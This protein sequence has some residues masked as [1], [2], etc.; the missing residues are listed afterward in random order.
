M[1]LSTPLIRKLEEFR[2]KLQAYRRALTVPDCEAAAQAKSDARL[3][4][5]E[6]KDDLRTL[7]VPRVGRD[8]AGSEFGMFETALESF[9]PQ[10]ADLHFK[11]IDLALGSLEE[12]IGRVRARELPAEAARLK[13]Q[14]VS[15]SEDLEGYRR[16]LNAGNLS[17]ARDMRPKL[18]QQIAVLEPRLNDIGVDTFF[19][20]GE[21]TFSTLKAAVTEMWSAMPVVVARR[22]AYALDNSFEM[23]AN[24]QVMLREMAPK[25]PEI[26]QLESGESPTIQVAQ[27]A[28]SATTAPQ[29]V[30]TA[31]EV[32]IVVQH[33][34][35]GFLLFAAGVLVGTVLGWSVALHQAAV[36]AA[37]WSAVD[38]WQK[39]SVSSQIIFPAAT[40]I[41]AVSGSMLASDLKKDG[42]PAALRW[43]GNAEA[44]LVIASAVAAA[45]TAR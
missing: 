20:E 36:I 32:R 1:P 3:L 6:V 35:R 37:F 5:G 26:V 21:D 28:A 8:S 4:Y 10:T 17:I 16:E 14:V 44:V 43:P 38:W 25:G 15:L 18:L 27:A 9:Q 41:L 29:L 2:S 34:W 24:A 45:L 13:R 22:T 11:A 23:L 7:K 39:K 31:P 40:A 19:W 12:A 42:W 33:G 30:G